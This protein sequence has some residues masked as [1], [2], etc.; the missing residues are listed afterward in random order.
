[1]SLFVLI[2]G[3]ILVFLVILFLPFYFSMIRPAAKRKLA[4]QSGKPGTGL[5]KEVRDTGVTINRGIQ[6]RLTLEIR[7]ADGSPAF[8]ATAT[9][10]VPRID[11]TRFR[12]GVEVPV[13]YDPVKKTAV[14]VDSEG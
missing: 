2:A 11:P 3:S 5:I 14:V 10:L 9:A 1:M 13:K 4:L 7:P 6:V 8:E 12:P